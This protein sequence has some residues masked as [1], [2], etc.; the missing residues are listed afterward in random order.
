[1]T[2]TKSRK[3]LH[4]ALLAVALSM[5]PR[6]GFGQ[7]GARG[8]AGG[9]FTIAP[10]DPHAVN[11]GSPSTTY[12]NTSPDSTTRGLTV[13]LGWTARPQVSLGVEIGVPFQ[14]RLT[15]TY[16]YFNPF[17][18]ESRY[19]DLTFFGVARRELPATGKIHLALTG[20]AGLVQ[21]RSQERISPGQF[22]TYIFGPFGDEHLVSRWTW[23]A[24]GG[25]DLSVQAARHVAIVPQFR[26][27]FIDRGRKYAE[28]AGVDVFGFGFDSLGYRVGLGIRGKF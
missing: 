28:V 1:M 4:A 3:I 8:Y 27:L 23:G 15:Q 25:A 13:E 24:T 12:D 26:V 2:P 16:Y 6:T 21:Q 9:A 5:F 20:G 7:G 22:G 19:R 17:I 14:R 18:K 10:G 11:G